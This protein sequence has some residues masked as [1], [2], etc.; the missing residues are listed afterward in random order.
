M[1]MGARDSMNAILV[2]SRAIFEI[3]DRQPPF[4]SVGV[5]GGGGW[6]RRWGAV[7]SGGQGSHLISTLL[8]E[9][10]L[11]AVPEG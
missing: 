6:W 11:G 8:A 2:G 9:L 5:A 10:D 1:R 7:G 3:F 4:T